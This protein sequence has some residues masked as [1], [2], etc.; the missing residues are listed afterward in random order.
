M[1]KYFEK[2]WLEFSNE[3]GNYIKS[4]VGN[5]H[6]AEDILQEVYVK[7]FRNLD[8]LEKKNAV[9]SWIFTITR[10]TIID[11]YKKKKDI[12]VLPDVFADIENKDA[13][14]DNMNREISECL[15]QMIFDVPEKY[16]EVYDMHL[17][18]KM[19]HKEI[20]EELDISLANS[21][22]RLKRAK[23]LLKDKLVECCDFELDAYGN[24]IEYHPKGKCDGCDG[25]C[26]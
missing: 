3:L 9:K 18:K 20:A 16:H 25:E 15:K 24:I 17:N 13:D 21:K 12:P 14:E 5:A 2:L 7:I 26:N 8:T 23:Q 11:Y 10:N 22:V 19:K 6:D 1:D 4:K